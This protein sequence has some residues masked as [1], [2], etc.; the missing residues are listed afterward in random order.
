MFSVL[1][2]THPQKKEVH[3]FANR[4]KSIANSVNEAK[5][6][7][8]PL[9]GACKRSDHLSRYRV[10]FSQRQVMLP[11]AEDHYPPDCQV[12]QTWSSQ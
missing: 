9:V 10:T 8:P 4:T 1:R 6:P 5:E 3:T 12:S 7:S 11:Q 2:K